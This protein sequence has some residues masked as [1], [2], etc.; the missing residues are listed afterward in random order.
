MLAI[1]R[2]SI[3][4]QPNMAIDIRDINVCDECPRQGLEFRNGIDPDNAGAYL[5]FCALDAINEVSVP[6]DVDKGAFDF[7][8]E[9]PPLYRKS[10]ISRCG[11]EI[12]RGA[13]GNWKIEED[14]IVHIEQPS[15][16]VDERGFTPD[17]DLEPDDVFERSAYY[18]D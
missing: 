10:A 9:A 8:S 1:L 13:C 6:D 18:D 12:G 15:L 17:Y 3:T 16:V 7:L 4:I 11:I 2:E 5:L 14:T